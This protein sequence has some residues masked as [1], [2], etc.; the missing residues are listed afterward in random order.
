[1]FTLSLLAVFILAN[2]ACAYQGIAHDASA[3]MKDANGHEIGIAYFNE[4]ANGLVHIDVKASGL[5]PGQHGIHVHEKG[6]CSP[7]FAAAG[8]HYNPLHKKHG[9][10]NPDGPHAGDLPDL[11]VD[12]SGAGYLNTTSDRF[13]ISA[14][15]TSLFDSDGSAIV[16]HAGPDDQ[17]TDPA[18]NSGDR[19]AC[20]VIVVGTGS[21]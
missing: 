4:D 21:K 11:Q 9:L 1:M 10:N 16:I 18:G 6:N 8:S 12:E 3:I 2:S 7:T 13:T 15:P 19:V 5:S 20:G 14:G 17:M